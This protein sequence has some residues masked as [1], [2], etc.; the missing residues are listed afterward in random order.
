MMFAIMT[1]AAVSFTA[2]NIYLNR[3]P[4]T[5]VT[6]E[7]RVTGDVNAFSDV[8]VDDDNGKKIDEC[9][10]MLETRL[11]NITCTSETTETVQ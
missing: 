9:G 11:A 3:H 1:S 4:V 7:L 2:L 10:Y 6:R 8:I 5:T